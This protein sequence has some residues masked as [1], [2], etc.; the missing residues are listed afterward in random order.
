MS[1]ELYKEEHELDYDQIKESERREND[2]E[3]G[4]AESPVDNSG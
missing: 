4:E 1:E 2:T 3:P